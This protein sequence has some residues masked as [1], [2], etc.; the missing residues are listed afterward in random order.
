MSVASAH[1]APGP[2]KAVKPAIAPEALYPQPSGPVSLVDVGA[3]LGDS[4][5]DSDVEEVWAR[6]Q[7][8]GVRHVLVTGTSVERSRSARDLAHRMGAGV[9]FTAGVH[10]HDA[11]IYDSST[12]A[13]LT[14]LAGDS[15]CVAIGECGLDFNRNFSSV[16]A[17]EAA[18]VGQLELAALLHKPLFVHCRDAAPRLAELLGAA[19]PRLSAPV[20][21]HCFTGSAAEAEALLALSPLVHIG[22]TGWICDEREGRAEAL[23]QAV[24]LIPDDRLLLETDAPYL[25]PRSCSSSS[26]LRPRR[27]EPCMLPWVAVAVAACRGVSVAQ[28]AE[29][30]TRNATRV[31]RL[32]EARM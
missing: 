29:Q 30:T 11:S 8:A 15:K 19:A 22:I 31:F 20:V 7:E 14:Q 13:A 12:A 24:R 5:F 27:N 6:A 16:E 9:W 18:L 25:T 4:A 3:N 32:N 2:A 21:V 1:A 28:L 23:A 26:K 17:Q 10:P